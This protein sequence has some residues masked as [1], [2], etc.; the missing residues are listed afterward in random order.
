MGTY[1]V[2]TVVAVFTYLCFGKKSFDLSNTER[3]PTVLLRRPDR[4]NL[5]TSRH[6]GGRSKRKVFVVRIDDAFTVE[7]PDRI[8]RR[9]DGCKGSNSSDLEYEQNLLET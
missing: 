6:R 3:R 7:R 5:E 4:C 2:Q 1:I 9:P 8:S